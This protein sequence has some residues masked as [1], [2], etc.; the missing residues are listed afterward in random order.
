MYYGTGGDAVTAG[1]GWSTK[2]A[3]KVGSYECLLPE[4]SCYCYRHE[5]LLLQHLEVSIL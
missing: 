2:L 1:P 4:S 5:K 3:V